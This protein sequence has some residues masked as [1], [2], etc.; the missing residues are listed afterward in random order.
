MQTEKLLKLLKE[1]H[2][3]SLITNVEPRMNTN[4]HKFFCH[5]VHRGHRECHREDGKN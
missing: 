3:K 4:K 1:K 2:L 5:R